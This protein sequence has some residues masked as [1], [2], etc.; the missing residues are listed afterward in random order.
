MGAAPGG[1][2]TLA[3]PDPLATTAAQQLRRAREPTIRM[4]RRR[5]CGGLYDWL[6]LGFGGLGLLVVGWLMMGI[7]TSHEAESLAAR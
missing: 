2:T 5:L 6:F 3:N 1:R 7:R 4:S